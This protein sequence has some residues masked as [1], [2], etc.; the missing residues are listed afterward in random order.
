MVFLAVLCLLGGIEL[1]S[2]SDGGQLG[3]DL[4]EAKHVVGWWARNR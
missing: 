3:E 2:W 4:V 1:A